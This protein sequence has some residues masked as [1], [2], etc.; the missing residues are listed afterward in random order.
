MRD[1]VEGQMLVNLVADEKEVLRADHFRQRFEFGTAE[2]APKGCA[3][4]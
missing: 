2:D 4:Y 1:A 3:A